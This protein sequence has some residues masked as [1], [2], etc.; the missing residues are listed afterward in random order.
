MVTAVGWRFKGPRFGTHRAAVRWPESRWRYVGPND[1]LDLE[2]ALRFEAI[3]LEGYRSDPS[4][5]PTP[6]S[7]RAAR[8]PFQRF[9]GYPS[10]C[11]TGRAPLLARPRPLSR[12]PALGN[13]L[14]LDA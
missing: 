3:R 1:P 13:S 7:K 11:R 6:P 10:S 2:K 14:K 4:Q 9:P 12:P 8:N 5:D